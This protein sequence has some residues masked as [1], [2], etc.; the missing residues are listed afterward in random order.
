MQITSPCLLGTPNQAEAL[1]QSWYL[2]W[3]VVEFA[4]Y[5]R[6]VEGSFRLCVTMSTRDFFSKYL[7]DTTEQCI[8]YFF[9][10]YILFS[11]CTL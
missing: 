11:V 9:F 3:A 10:I 1:E 8:A 7:D 2:F 4:K 5:Y 6:A